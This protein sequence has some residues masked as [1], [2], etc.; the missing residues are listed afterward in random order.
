MDL[1]KTTPATQISSAEKQPRG[2]RLRQWVQEPLGSIIAATAA[3]IG[4]F[5]VVLSGMWLISLAVN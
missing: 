3:T 4:S 2:Y 1:K 5:G